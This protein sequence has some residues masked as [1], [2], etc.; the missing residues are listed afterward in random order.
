VSVG[1]MYCIDS[2]N[3]TGVAKI[4]SIPQAS[5][6]PVKAMPFNVTEDV[7][8]GY[9]VCAIPSCFV[10]SWIVATFIGLH[11]VRF[12]TDWHWIP[13]PFPSMRELVRWQ[14]CILLCMYH[15]IHRT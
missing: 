11:A 6:A 15:I 14:S 13:S 10:S 4:P 7:V 2:K 1:L 3:C 12:A 5:P 8:E 9:D